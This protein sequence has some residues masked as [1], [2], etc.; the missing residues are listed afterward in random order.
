MVFGVVRV[1]RIKNFLKAFFLSNHRFYRV[2]KHPLH[3]LNKCPVSPGMQIGPNCFRHLDKWGGDDGGVYN[4]E[5]FSNCW[6]SK[7]HTIYAISHEWK[8]HVTLTHLFFES[9]F[10]LYDIIMW[11]CQIHPGIVGEWGI[12]PT[13]SMFEC[14][15]VRVLLTELLCCCHVVLPSQHKV[16][17]CIYLQEKCKQFN[18]YLCELK[19]SNM[20]KFI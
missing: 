3:S 5:Y 20:A 6:N 2:V 19:L 14:I 17:V 8:S 15:G 10:I 4:Y 9:Q 18:S 11:W 1:K 12:H 13:L 16:F 7:F